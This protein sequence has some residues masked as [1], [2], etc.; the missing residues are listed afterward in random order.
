MSSITHIHGNNHPLH[1]S[2]VSSATLTRD[3]PLILQNESLSFSQKETNKGYSDDT[4]CE[5]GAGPLLITQH[6]RKSENK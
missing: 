3:R 2:R 5:V 6:N 4:K 1:S